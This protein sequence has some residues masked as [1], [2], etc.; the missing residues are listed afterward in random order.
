MAPEKTPTKRKLMAEWLKSH[1]D[2]ALVTHISPDG[3]TLGSALA[4]MHALNAMGKRAVVCNRDEMPGYL[5]FLPGWEQIVTPDALPFPPKAVLAVDCADEA[6]MG[7][8]IGLIKEGVDA[9]VIDHHE[10]N[11]MAFTPA[12]V[13]GEEAATG[14]LVQSLLSE[15]GLLM[16]SDMAMCLYAAIASD[17]GNFNFGNTTPEALCAAAECL[18]AGFDLA[19]LSFRLFRMRSQGRTR[20]L[21]RALNGIEYLEDG[22][23]ALIR[24]KKSEFAEYGAIDSDTEGV[25]NFGIDTEGVEVAILAVERTGSTKFSLRS[26]NYVNVAQAAAALGGGGHSRAAGVTL[27]L[28]MDEAVEQVLSAMVKA[29]RENG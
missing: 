25:V 16:T 18:K 10:T 26:R 24:L 27:Q 13:E 4:L 2:I 21:G 1:D 19:D 23:I 14:V 17:T 11:R 8:A 20:L 28:P 7:S 29:V 9:A 22:R 15:L 3:D 6:R 12:W 5:K